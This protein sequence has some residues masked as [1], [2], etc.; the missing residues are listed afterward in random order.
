M[1]EDAGL[2]KEDHIIT[3]CTGGIRSAY[4]QLVME[5]CGF[6]NSEN[7]D[8]LSTDGVWKEIW[9]NKEKQINEI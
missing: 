7:Y 4:M 9:R 1:F 3:Y 2:S 8:D 6:E 5:M